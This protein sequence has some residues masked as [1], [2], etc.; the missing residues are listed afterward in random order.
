MVKP[1]LLYHASPSK[2]LTIIQPRNEFPRFDSEQDLV[3]A[4]QHLAVAA[5]FLAP[6]SIPTEMS[7]FGDRYI[8]FIEATE[9][10]YKAV[11]TGGAIYTLPSTSFSTNPNVGMGENE[12]TSS[13]AVTP[14]TKQLFATSLEAIMLQDAEYYFV[15]PADMKIIQSNPAQALDIIALR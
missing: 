4:T 7:I 14:I 6:R 15:S 12:W 13:V 3:F 10:A 9:D 11:D 2:D 5:M 1:E 8:L